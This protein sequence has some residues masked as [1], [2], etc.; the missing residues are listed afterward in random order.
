MRIRESVVLVTGASSGLGRA[1]TER[2]A[3]AGARL[4]AHGRDEAA[5]ADLAARTG[6]VPLSADLALPGEADRLAQAALAV[7]GRLDIV[8]S[9][10]GQGWAGQFADMPPGDLDRLIA[11][12]L[13]APVR[14]TRAVLPAMLAAGRG[15]LA[16][17]G[18]IAGRT[19]V[20]GEALYAATKAGLDTFAESL[21]FELSGRGIGVGVFVPGVVDTPF[22]DRRGRAYQRSSPRPRPAPE[23]AAALVRMIETGRAEAYAPRWLRLP[24]AVRGALPGVYRGLAGRFG[25]G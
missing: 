24:V 2:L 3:G 12:N 16:F 7:H 23:V 6:A 14:L 11:V 9:N 17:V 25:G 13:A 10:A 4:I 19:G 8:V 21:R 20:A 22:F 5:L 15:Y 1:T 18:S